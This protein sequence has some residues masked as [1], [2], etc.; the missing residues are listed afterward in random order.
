MFIKFWLTQLYISSIK[1]HC[2]SSQEVGYLLG[3]QENMLAD[4]QPEL[5]LFRLQSEAESP[6][7]V[8]DILHAPADPHCQQRIRLPASGRSACAHSLSFRQGNE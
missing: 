5:V 7:I 2:N 4:G 1:F 3:V 6:D 8:A